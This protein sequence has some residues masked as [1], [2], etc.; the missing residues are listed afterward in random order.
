[1]SIGRSVLDLRQVQFVMLRPL[2]H[3]AKVGEEATVQS[4]V[5]V[6]VFFSVATCYAEPN[7]RVRPE[8][9]VTT[10]DEP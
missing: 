7:D 6:G 5:T 8:A 1:L 3:C 4:F 10:R 2:A 9:V